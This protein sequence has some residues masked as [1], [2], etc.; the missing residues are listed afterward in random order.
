M[1]KAII[2]RKI[3]QLTELYV[4]NEHTCMK[5]LGLHM[6]KDTDKLYIYFMEIV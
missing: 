6:C 1:F 3:N 2:G 5:I 4:V